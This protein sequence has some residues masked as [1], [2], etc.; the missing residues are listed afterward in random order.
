[1]PHAFSSPRVIEPHFLRNAIDVL[2]IGTGHASLS[3]A[4]ALGRACRSASI[5]YSDEYSRPARSDL[6]ADG[7]NLT[8]VQTGMI[9]ELKTSFKTLLFA[10]TVAR[11]IHETGVIFE[12][13]DRAGQ[14]WKGRK[15]ILATGCH[16]SL[17]E[18][19]GY[20]DLWGT[21]M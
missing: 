5:F 6:H 7:G 8:S 19:P 11:S 17:P 16:K 10:N 9:A 20:K 18:I 4:L 21:T 13:V 1:M 12:V 14:C 3:A 2:I 15:V